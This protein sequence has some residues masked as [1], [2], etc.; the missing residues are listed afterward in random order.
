MELFIAAVVCLVLALSVRAYIRW[1]YAGTVRDARFETWCQ[2]GSMLIAVQ[3]NDARTVMRTLR[4]AI[5]VAQAREIVNRHGPWPWQCYVVSVEAV[6]CANDVVTVVTRGCRLARGKRAS[7][8]RTDV[9]SI[10]R[11][12]LRHDAQR[13]DSVWLAPALHT[14]RAARRPDGWQVGADG[15]PV[16]LIGRPAWLLA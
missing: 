8:T 3:T 14:E 11:S 15:D 6:Q 1:F 5:D 7:A 12:V 4:E 16:P 9:E 2:R 10:W 13:V